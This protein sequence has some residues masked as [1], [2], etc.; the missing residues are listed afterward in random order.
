MNFVH[1]DAIKDVLPDGE[2]CLVRQVLQHLSN[3][4][5]SIIL[6]KLTKFKFVLIS[7]HHPAELYQYNIDK[8]AGAAIRAYKGSGVYLEKP[9]FEKSASVLFETPVSPPLVMEGE[10]IVT[11]LLTSAMG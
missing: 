6:E 9:P 8:P 4:Q 10:K 3:D 2:L 5:I 7:E 1:L 11:Y